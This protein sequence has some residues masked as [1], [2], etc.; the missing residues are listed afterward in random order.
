[1]S[2]DDVNPERGIM[3]MKTSRRSGFTLLEIMIAV[4]ILGFLAGLAIPAFMRSRATSQATR[5]VANMVK[6]ESAKEQWAMETFA[7]V[8]SVCVKADLL[9]YFKN[10][11]FPIC[12]GGG[13]YDTLNP[14]GSNV[15]CS[16]DSVTA[17]HRLKK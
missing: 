14:V 7:D 2:E 5:C 10:D 4:T 11:S 3:T 15:I 8:G 13:N 9:P 6:I 12:P 16:I 1:M 17:P